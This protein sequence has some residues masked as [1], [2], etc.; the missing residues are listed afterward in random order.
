MQTKKREELNK[1]Y[2]WDLTLLYKS[3]N[4]YLKDFE[5]IKSLAEESY[6]FKGKLNNREDILK[7]YK[8]WDKLGIKL[9]R[10][11]V[12]LSLRREMNGKDVKA[13]EDIAELENFLTD[14][15]QKSAYEQVEL[16]ALNDEF[17]DELINDP[18]FKDYDRNLEDI[19]ESKKH[20]L[21]ETREQMLSKI[22][23]FTG[24]S[25]I[26]SKIDDIELKFGKI[27]L[28]N[29]EEVEMTNANMGVYTRDASQRVR[30]AA[31]ETIHKGY[32]DFNLTISENFINFLKY[33]DSMADFRYYDGTL[34]AQLEGSKIDKSVIETLVR[35][36]NDN[37]GYFYDFI[38][39]LKKKLN[40]KT[41]YNT[42][43]Y[44]PV[45]QGIQSNYTYEE[46][47]DIVKDALKVMGKDYIDVL[48]KLFSSR[49]IDVYPTENKG[50]GAFSTGCY[51][52]LPMVLLN[53]TGTFN[54]I[55]TI[56]H[57]LGHSMHTYYSHKNQCF[58][59][60]GY[61]IFVAE[62]ASTVNE[63]LL[64]RYMEKHAKNCEERKSYI[65]SFLGTFYAT[66]Y[67]QTMFTEFELFAHGAVHKNQVLSYEKLNTFYG[68]LQKKYF[69]KNVTMNEN[70]NVE[71]SRIPH[72]YRPFYVYKYAT[73]LVSACSIVANILER[74]EEYVENY[75]KKFL[76][77]GSSLDPVDILKLAD[78]D[79]TSEDTYSKAF[80]FFKSYVDELDKI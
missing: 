63:L 46:A 29:G 53:Y 43:V 23:S 40:L 33:R 62:I 51:D 59:K 47:V 11:E 39:V 56:A 78:V 67:R 26:F 35:E 30:K 68:N 21:D 75:Y 50:G 66:I 20:I 5:H 36:V 37:L 57:E 74:G 58:A 45:S 76:S 4:D 12:Y 55:S 7:I 52:C 70:A 72:F 28:E 27:K 17:I 73:G 54:D 42:D 60:S 71:W 8:L 10:M 1:K 18:D 15:N 41:F 13:L 9:E 80:N 38:K 79:I 31:S 2:T 49:T 61:D 34:N 24:F 3:H 22:S 19:K 69:G 64:F 16:C 44:A 77:S 6:S 65:A 32:K 25:D 14:Y 48:S